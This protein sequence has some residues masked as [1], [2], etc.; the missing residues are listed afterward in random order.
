MATMK[1]SY[2]ICMRPYLE[3]IKTEARA[4][5]EPFFSGVNGR[6]LI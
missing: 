6:S 3:Y 5:I 2:R 1:E 4:R